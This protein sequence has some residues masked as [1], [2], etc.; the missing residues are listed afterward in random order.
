VIELHR[1]PRPAFPDGRGQLRETGDVFVEVA[2]DI[3]RRAGELVDRGIADGNQA[4][5]AFGTFPVESG[6]AAR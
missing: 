1:R 3:A 5:P 2:A 4:G 6:S